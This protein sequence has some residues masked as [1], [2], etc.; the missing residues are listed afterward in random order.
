M[1]TIQASVI[2][3]RDTRAELISCSLTE[4]QSNEVL[5][6]AR[7]S[8]ISPG[9][10]LAALTRVW[11]D[12]AFRANPGYAL[13]GEV[14]AAGKNQAGIQPGQRVISLVGH[15]SAALAS[16]E[17][18]VTLP[19]PDSVNDETASFLPLASVA[20]HALRRAEL[21]MG[22]TVLIVGLGIIG[23]IAVTLARLHGAGRMIA[24][25]LSDE[26]LQ[27]AG[28]RGA[29]ELVN[30]GK[31]DPQSAVLG[32]TRGE[33]A[34][35]ILDATGSTWHI[36]QNFKLAALGGRI[37]TVGIVDE[38][39]QLQFPKEFMQRELTLLAASQPRCPTTPTIRH[40]WTQQ[41]NRQYLLEMMA[42]GR[43]K[44]QDL[45]THR[46]P[47][48]D[49]PLVYETLKSADQG[50]LGCILDWSEFNTE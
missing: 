28:E 36:P 6:R 15:A 39:V 43:L 27:I 31:V 37:V 7:L 16:T 45:I 1:S 29:D 17:P 44:V 22:E 2:T 38:S 18:W 12:A 21:E 42:Q 11:D 8:L 30:S 41:A 32:L 4:P 19:V 10:E 9:T 23:Q 24:I 46:F 47:A 20:L 35:V 3:F 49:A 5:V 40:P 34:P 25:D 26:R 14:I 50:M 33:G 13:M 48:S